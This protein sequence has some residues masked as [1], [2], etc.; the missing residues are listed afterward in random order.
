MKK[1]FLAA[2]AVATLALVGCEKKTVVDEPTQD[3][4]KDST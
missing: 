4:Q 2:L 1:F 3:N